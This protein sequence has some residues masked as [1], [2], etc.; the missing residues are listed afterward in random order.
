M[1]PFSYPP[2]DPR[3]SAIAFLMAQ[4]CIARSRGDNALEVW[5]ENLQEHYLL[6]FGP[7]EFPSVDIVQV[8]GLLASQAVK[9]V[10]YGEHQG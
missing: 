5:E 9:D 1:S 10:R 8:D 4:G 2:E 6:T 7:R 3:L